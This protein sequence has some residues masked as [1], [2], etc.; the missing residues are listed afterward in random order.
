MW[1]GGGAFV[2]SLAA[3]TYVF[4]VAW[5]APPADGGGWRALAIDAGLFG[6][7]AL[8]HSVFARESVKGWISR[9]VPAHLLRSCYVWTASALL[10][11]VLALWQPIAGDLYHVAGPASLANAGVQLFGIWLIAGSVARISALELAGIEPAAGDALQIGGPYRWVRHPLY[12]G[13]L[14]VVFGAAHMTA[15]RLAFAS[16]SAAYL[17]LAIPWEERSLLRAFGEPYARYQR[18][19]RWRVLPYVY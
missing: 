13:W 6:V 14:L 16:T 12:L 2:L 10:V 4:A 1:G 3:C 17:L 18:A 7:F 11:A 19:V 8:H 15:N 9:I 5:E